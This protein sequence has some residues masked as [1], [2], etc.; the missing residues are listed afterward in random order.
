MQPHFAFWNSLSANLRALFSLVKIWDNIEWE[1]NVEKLVCKF[2]Q[3][4]VKLDE[5]G[6]YS[7]HF[8]LI[9]LSYIFLNGKYFATVR[10]LYTFESLSNKVVSEYFQT[11]I[12]IGNMQ[13]WQLTTLKRPECMENI[14]SNL[15]PTLRRTSDGKSSFCSFRKFFSFQWKQSNMLDNFFRFTVYSWNRIY[16]S[17]QCALK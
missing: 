2:A 7:C 14:Y 10:L 11:A 8:H 17:S 15:L 16:G 9:W 5:A 12:W 1:K 13:H 4:H 3:M 6:K